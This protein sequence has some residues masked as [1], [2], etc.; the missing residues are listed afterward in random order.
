MYFSDENMLLLSL[1]AVRRRH[2][3]K[4]YKS[5]NKSSV[6]ECENSSRTFSQANTDS[7]QIPS[8]HSN[9]SS[10]YDTDSDCYYDCVP[11][12]DHDN[13]LD[14]DEDADFRSEHRRESVDMVK[15]LEDRRERRSP[16]VTVFHKVAPA[17]AEIS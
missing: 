4:K 15:E 12:D 2:G 7:C 6:Y 11:V 10:D 14:S 5:G 13:D 16:R 8:S 3:R 9:F 17:A 1:V